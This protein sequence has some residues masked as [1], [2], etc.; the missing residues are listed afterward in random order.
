[1][2]LVFAEATNGKF[3]KAAH[4]VVTYGAKTAAALGTECVA[5]TLGDVTDAGDLGR[6]GASKVYNLSAPELATFDGSVYT[7]AIAGAARQLGAKVIILLHNS[8]GKNLVGRLAARLDAGSVPGANAIPSTDGGFSVR[9]SVFS[10]KAIAD[11]S[12][13]TDYKVI[14]LSGNSIP[15]EESGS[16]VSVES[17][18]VDLPAAKTKVLETKRAEGITPLPEAEL[19]V[20]GGRGLKG[21][22]NWGVIQDLADALGA[23]TA[24]SRP[25]A[26]VGWRPHHEHVGQ[27][28]VAI[29]PNLYIAAGI[30]GA[31]QH[32]A[33]VNSSKTIVVINKDPEAPFFKAADY[34]VVAD[35]FDVLPR[36]TEAIKAHKAG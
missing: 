36:L 29:R 8:T 13:N 22:E 25:V 31:I 18:S 34:G 20:S 32:L 16:A 24:C 4:E 2:V 11:V 1:M 17:I 10:G 35:L 14:S 15:V 7:A 5:L 3:K 30:S 6:F 19:V 27:T 12:I 23:T 33:G 28:G 21:P 26:D 9:K